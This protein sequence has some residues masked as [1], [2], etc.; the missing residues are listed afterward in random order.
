M[1]IKIYSPAVCKKPAVK[2]GDDEVVLCTEN[3]LFSPFHHYT[4]C[5][6]LCRCWQEMWKRQSVLTPSSTP[7]GGSMVFS[8]S[9]STWTQSSLMCCSTLSDRNLPSPPT[10][11]IRPQRTRSTSTWALSYCRT[12][13]RIQGPGG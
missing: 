5:V 13:R 4:C 7:S 3:S 6:P 12:W 2:N 11:S 8:L 1:L 10:F 9:D